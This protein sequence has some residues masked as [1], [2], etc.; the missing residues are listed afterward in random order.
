MSLSYA[1]IYQAKLKNRNK[2]N[3]EETINESRSPKYIT[4]I[5]KF[6]SKQRKIN[7]ND[8]KMKPRRIE[9]KSVQISYFIIFLY[10][11]K[12]FKTI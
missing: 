1:E 12:K 8:E 10:Y 2:N 6:P 9:S 7:K 3:K 5:K 4:L 11:L